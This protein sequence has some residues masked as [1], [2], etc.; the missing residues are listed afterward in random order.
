MKR[1]PPSD[2]GPS[3]LGLSRPKEHQKGHRA[4]KPHWD[5]T[6]ARLAWRTGPVTTGATTTYS[7]SAGSTSRCYC[8]SSRTTRPGTSSTS[9]GRGSDCRGRWTR[10][11]WT[12]SSSGCR[13]GDSRSNSKLGPGTVL[14]SSRPREPRGGV[15]GEFTGR[16]GW[17]RNG[18]P[19]RFEGALYAGGTVRDTSEDAAL[20]R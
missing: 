6:G 2:Q 14:R 3:R 17:G 9:S 4:P 15:E 5:G 13:S 8:P 18:D 11:T 7:S 20:R 12:G 10:S 1:L 19:G 16:A